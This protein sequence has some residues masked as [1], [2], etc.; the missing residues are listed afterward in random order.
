MGK[1]LVGLRERDFGLRA[2][3]LCGSDAARGLSQLG[4]QAA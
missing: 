3:G 1:R 4:A 2:R